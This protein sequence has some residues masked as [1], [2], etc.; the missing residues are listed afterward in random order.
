M[1]A[2]FVPLILQP[3]A[4]VPFFDSAAASLFIALQA[5]HDVV[6]LTNVNV[7]LADV[8]LRRWTYLIQTVDGRAWHQ[9]LFITTPD[10]TMTFAVTDQWKVSEFTLQRP[11][12]DAIIALILRYPTLTRVGYNVFP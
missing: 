3:V 12:R 10:P 11:I 7:V 9:N 4:V 8:I 6:P 2:L 1:G 5:M